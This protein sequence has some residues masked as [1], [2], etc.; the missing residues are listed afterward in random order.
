M[1]AD[2]EEPS[3]TKNDNVEKP[4]MTKKVK[5]INIKIYIMICLQTYACDHYKHMHV[6]I[7]F[8]YKH[9]HVTLHID[10]VDFLMLTKIL[11]NHMM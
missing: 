8:V 10:F 9:I 5:R 6:I 1:E 3:M 4:F 2:I 7:S 11:R